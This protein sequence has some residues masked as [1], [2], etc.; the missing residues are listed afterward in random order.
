MDSSHSGTDI[1]VSTKWTLN[2]TD[3][4]GQAIV[5]SVFMIYCQKTKSKG[6]GFY[7]NNGYII[8]NEHVVRNCDASEILAISA[9]GKQYKF[10]NVIIDRDKD[11]AALKPLEHINEGLS[12]GSS[13]NLKIG[14]LVITWGYPLEY[15]GPP[16]LLSVGYLSGF[17]NHNT[18]RT[19]RKHLVVN[20]AFNQGNSGGALFLA[21]ENK[22]IGVVVN[23]HAPLTQFQTNALQE[24]A[25]N[26]SGVVF[27]APDD[28][29]NNREFVESEL[30]ADL[31]QGFIKLTQ[32]MIGEAIC[33]S[34]LRSFLEKSN[35]LTEHCTK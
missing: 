26:K 30:V 1:P 31:L 10:S 27:N 32:V 2:A 18:N 6:T 12:L 5:N 17:I 11:L 22:V 28:T 25:N 33:V 16:P 3:T 14:A 29:G 13:D 9:D 34:E 7:L 23:K 35:I 24:L 4:V 21:N 8:T 20:G 19:A 15:N